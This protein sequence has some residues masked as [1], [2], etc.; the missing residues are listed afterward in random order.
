MAAAL[1][2][3][4]SQQQQAGDE[5]ARLLEEALA[6]VRNHA[7]HMRRCLDA[8]RLMDALKNASSMLAEL[9]SSALG[10][11]QY[12]Q[13]YM[14]AFDSLRYLAAYL[15]EAHQSG[16]HHLADLYELVQYAGNIVPRLYLMITVG[17]VYM[18]VEGAPVR[19]IM[20]DLLEMS[21]G[22]QHPIRGLF[23][24]HYLSGQSR[25]YLPSGEEE[26]ASGN[27]RDSISFVL[28][29]F[30]EMNKLWVRLQHQGH[31]RDR[32]KRE[33]ERRELRLLVGTNLVRLSQL[34]AADLELYSGT[35]LPAILEQVVQCR[36]VLA[37][38]YLMEVITQ[39]FADD[40][41]LRTLDQFLSATAKLNTHS[42]IRQIVSALIDRLAS[43]AAR[44][45]ENEDPE[46]R[47][48]KEEGAANRLASKIQRIRVSNAKNNSSTDQVVESNPDETDPPTK[49]RGIPQDVPLFEVFWEQIV[50]LVKARPDIP[51]QDVS[52]LLLSLANL[53]LNCYPDKLEYVDKIFS[54]ARDK[55]IDYADSPDLY[56]PTTV[57]AYLALLLAPLSSY[58]SLLTLF[59]IP[60]Y[61]PLLHAQPY[62][63][64]RAIAAAVSHALL[65]TDIILSSVQDVQDVLELLKV[66]IV[67]SAPAQSSLVRKSQNED[68]VEEQGWIA[69]IIHLCKSEDIDI[70][71]SILEALSKA[72]IE[73]GDRIKYTTPSLVTQTILLAHQC[74]SQEHLE[75]DWPNKLTAMFKFLHQLISMLYSRMALADL[76][77]RLFVNAGQIADS[78]GAEDTAYE[79]FAQ[80][81]TIYEDS[82]SESRTQYQALMIISGGLYNTK[83]F[84]NENYENL[85][86]KAALHGAKLLKKPDQARAVYSASHLWWSED[87]KGYRDGK[88]VLDCLQKSLKIA[89]ACMDTASSVE[90]FVE[91]LNRYGYHFDRANDAVTVKYLN[92]LIELVQTNLTSLDTVDKRHAGTST[93]AICEYE[94][95]PAEWIQNFFYRTIKHMESRIEDEPEKWAGVKIPAS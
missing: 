48:L 65:N 68:E 7:L 18:G 40:L 24:R 51:L 2:A 63:T 8:A 77:L 58:Q 64:R 38:E 95:H 75:N 52:A 43:Y 28:T 23:L 87:E 1:V 27:L 26:S 47:R 81:F 56:A 84:G 44:E 16:K 71:F 15:L 78:C 37:Q 34:C 35:I 89:D 19:E 5:Q 32:D 14:A 9:R 11:K 94:G 4:S 22:V 91:I 93:S 54:F 62:S 36:D 53:S 50:N 3:Q 31:S 12:Y 49:F 66:I 13:V 59:A 29:N 85:I 30:I 57:N 80:A 88:R 46:E 39:V 25:D 42:N 61:L 69:R 6:V 60:F 55:M 67:E 41:H 82:I 72:C 20:K 76:C 73:G 10:P 83:S 45:S 86:T 17:T 21:R 74:Y 70:Q 79:Y 92:G 33:Q 90:L